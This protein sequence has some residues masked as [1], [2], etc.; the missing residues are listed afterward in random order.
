MSAVGGHLP[1]M[2]QQLLDAA[3]LIHRYAPPGARSPGSGNGCFRARAGVRHGA[4][5][6]AAVV[7]AGGAGPGARMAA[8]RAQGVELRLQ[9]GFVFG[10]GL[11]E[12]AP[13][14]GGHRHGAGAQAFRPVCPAQPA[15]AQRHARGVATARPERRAMRTRRAPR[16][17]P[18]PRVFRSTRRISS[19]SFAYARRQA[20]RKN[21]RPFAMPFKQKEL[22]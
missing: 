1:P 17:G 15:L 19:E 7:G 22:A 9:A 20:W 4:G 16:S 3:V 2:R 12:Q 21:Y 18:H 14:L 10:C 5:G 13:L 8:G 6:R 11:F